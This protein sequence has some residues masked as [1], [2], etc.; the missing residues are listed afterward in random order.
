MF[1]ADD[2]EY[3]L[4]PKQ[5]IDALKKEVER[6]KKNPLG[7]LQEGESILEAINNLND[8]IRKLIDIFTKAGADLEK[9]YSGSS[10]VEDIKSIKDQNEQI[11]QGI[12]TVAD[13]VKDMKDDV[14]AINRPISPGPKIA[15]IRPGSLPPVPPET[16]DRNS[17]PA[18]EP[19]PDDFNEQ[20]PPPPQ[21]SELQGQGLQDNRKRRGLFSRK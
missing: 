14:G 3:E 21:Y 2:D 11:A 20:I 4:L 19:F 6:L 15:M 13:M 18:E 16:P 9:D 7:D 5:E 10:P 8:N 1:L 17:F 12:L